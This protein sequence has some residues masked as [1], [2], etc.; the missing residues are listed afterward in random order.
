MLIHRLHAY[1][2]SHFGCVRLFVTPWTVAYQAPLSMDSPGKNTGV[3][4]HAL[5]LGIFLTQGSNPS[6]LRLL[7][8][9]WIL[10]HGA[11]REAQYTDYVIVNDVGKATSS[12]IVI[13]NIM[14]YKT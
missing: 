2:L 12:Y 5:L 14:T 1:V 8:C 6:L 3:G 10:C 7:H 9:R 11:T 13:T 4:C